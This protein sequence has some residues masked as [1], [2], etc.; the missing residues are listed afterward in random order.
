MYY[1][2]PL[3]RVDNVLGRTGTRINSTENHDGRAVDTS[4]AVL[5][6]RKDASLL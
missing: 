5:C 1:G 2:L 3:T 4:Q 6:P